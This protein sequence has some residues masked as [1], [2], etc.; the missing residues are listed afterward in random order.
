[1]NYRKIYLNLIQSNLSNSPTSTRDT[2][3]GFENHHIIPLKWGSS[4]HPSNLVRLTYRQHYV[5][6][7]LLCKVMGSRFY[8]VGKNSREYADI[9][10]RVRDLLIAIATTPEAIERSRKHAYKTNSNRVYKSASKAVN[11]QR[12]ATLQAKY[13]TCPHCGKSGG[14]GLLRWHF[15]N[16]RFKPLQT[17]QEPS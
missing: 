17:L 11:L 5:A 7:K 10:N 1:M 3:K 16:C 8:M 6:H 14:G 12:S 9:K 13:Y 2:V 15:D 4:D